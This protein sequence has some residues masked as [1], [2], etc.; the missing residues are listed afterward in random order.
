MIRVY[1]HGRPQGQDTWSAAPAP[2]DK[3]YLNPFLDSRIGEDMNA[4]MQV[5]IWQENS[6]YSYIHRKN[7]L[8]KGNRPSAYF[9]ITVCFE[10]Q[11]CTKVATL[12]DLLESVYTQLCLNHLIEKVDKQEHF[13]VAQFKEQE[14]LLKQITSVIQ[15]NV[16]KYIAGTLNT[17]SNKGVDTTKS[18]IKFYSTVDV[19]SPQFV[20]DCNNNRILISSDY[21]SKDKLPVELKQQISVIESQKQQVEGERNLWQ[22]KAE[23]QQREN[24]VLTDKQKQLQEQIQTLQQQVS[25]I[26]GE[27]AKKY[28]FQINELQNSLS[29]LSK[30]LSQEK[31]QKKTLQEQN[32]SLQH[33]INKL[34][35]G[36]GDELSSNGT[37]ARGIS[38]QLQ[39]QVKEVRR[40]AS[41]FRITNT[42]ITMVATLFNTALLIII[43]VLYCSVDLKSNNSDNET[44]NI[45]AGTEVLETPIETPQISIMV[46]GEGVVL[47][48]D[49]LTVNKAGDISVK[50]IDSNNF[51]VSQRNITAQ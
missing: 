24:Q 21:P 35:Q 13:L 33:K 3:F 38:E 43:V 11:V 14:S 46:E 50:C 34:Q 16:D 45:N 5:D 15:Q 32:D 1:I 25:E 18:A 28:Q 42:T 44:T 4:V 31:Q 9:A 39:E 29:K 22:S 48:N 51:I 37:P 41:R 27:L 17:I 26:K 12:Y 36:N 6:Y 10:K 2:N 19:D 20:T 49:T 40:M 23:H 7:V 30:E 47:N 8:E